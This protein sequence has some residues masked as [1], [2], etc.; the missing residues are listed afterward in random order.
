[1]KWFHPKKQKDNPVELADRKEATFEIQNTLEAEIFD[2]D[3]LDDEQ[4]YFLETQLIEV[5]T[6]ESDQ[7]VSEK[8]RKGI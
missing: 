7:F 4:R 6:T 3:G 8:Q 2:D 1:M 5:E